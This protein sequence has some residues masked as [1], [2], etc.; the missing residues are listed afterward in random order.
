MGT[1][2]TQIATTA[3]V[4]ANGTMAIGGTVTSGTANRVLYIGGGGVLAQDANLTWDGSAFTVLGTGIV[5]SLKLT[6]TGSQ[7]AGGI[8]QVQNAETSTTQ[9][10]SLNG[11]SQYVGSF[12][13]LNI[14]SG[15]AFTI[16]CWAYVRNAGSFPQIL[17]DGGTIEFRLNSGT[18]KPEFVYDGAS[19]V[20]ANNAISLNTWTHLAVSYDGTTV[21]LYVN[22]VLDNSGTVTPSAIGLVDVGHRRG[23][24]CTSTPSLTNSGSPP[25]PATPRTSRPRPPNSAVT[26][27]RSSSCTSTRGPVPRSRT[28]PRTGTTAPHRAPRPGSPGTSRR[29]A[30]T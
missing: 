29:S 23:A 19:A 14:A 11:S 12:A 7:A 26:P 10:L 17:S 21:R 13:T 20:T 8:G 9:G 24:P 30:Q 22:G 5:N 6:A 4:L 18:L 25:R 3:F 16:E 27:A 2:T 15:A 28:A 1:N